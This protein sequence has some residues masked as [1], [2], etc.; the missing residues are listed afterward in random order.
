MERSE[1]NLARFTISEA[2]ATKKRKNS[3]YRKRLVGVF[4][5]LA[6]YGGYSIG[7][8]YDSMDA[9]EDDPLYNLKYEYPCMAE[10]FVADVT[11]SKWNQLFLRADK[12]PHDLWKK[13][14]VCLDA[15]YREYS[16]EQVAIVF[17]LKNNGE[18]VLTNES[19]SVPHFS[20]V[21]QIT[22]PENT[23]SV[24]VMPLDL[25]VAAKEQTCQK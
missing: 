19:L 24:K 18:W 11:I 22:T 15:G 7:D 13:F 2:V 12:I 10:V 9:N 17:A 25:Y 8:L 4:R 6:V 3:A 20:P 5:K 14:M 16:K 23:T 1:L 21:I